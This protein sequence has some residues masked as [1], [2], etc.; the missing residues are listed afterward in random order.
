MYHLKEL[1]FF[2]NFQQ[3][4]DRIKVENDVD[5]VSEGDFMKTDEVYTPLSSSIQMAE[6]EV[7]TVFSCCCCCCSYLCGCVRLSCS[8]MSCIESQ[9]LLRVLTVLSFM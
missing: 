3:S 6:P 4:V 1:C 5:C 2:Y 8:N 7:S 9:S